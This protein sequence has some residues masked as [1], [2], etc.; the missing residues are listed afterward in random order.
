MAIPFFILAG[1]FLAH[2]GVAKRMIAFTTSLVGHWPG[3]LGLAGVVACALFAAVS[4]SS[5][6]TVVAIGSIILPGDG[7][8]GLSE[9]LRRRGDHHLGGARHPRAAL[10]HPR[11]LRGVDEFLDRQPVPGRCDARRRPLGDA[12]ARHL[13]HRQAARLSAHAEGDLGRAPARLPR[14]RLGPVPRGDGDRRHLR[15]HLHADRGGRDR[16]GLRLRHRGVRLHA[17]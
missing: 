6:A 17:T 4:G 5:V 16:R 13:R 9:A 14:E 2:G 11:A 10:D 12:G 7:G 8:R 15:R 1:N 3:G